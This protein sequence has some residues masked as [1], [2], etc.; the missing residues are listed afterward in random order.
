ML[1]PILKA[2]CG[3]APQSRD[4][5]RSRVEGDKRT[6]L[7]QAARLRNTNDQR[8]GGHDTR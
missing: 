3:Y 1:S 6:E 4:R 8:G 5:T 2:T 7:R